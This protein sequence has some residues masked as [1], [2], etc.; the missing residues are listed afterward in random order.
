G[1]AASFKGDDEPCERASV[2]AVLFLEAGEPA[3][4]EE[5]ATLALEAVS[6]DHDRNV[7]RHDLR[8]S[9]PRYVRAL[10][11]YELGRLQP[12]ERDADEVLA[13]VPGH[14]RAL[15]LRAAI[16]ARRG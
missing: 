7:E 8:A 16:R 4:A 6:A 5:E 10:A 14:A 3:S 12:A 15:A 1:L 13:L 9:E 2:R 11:R